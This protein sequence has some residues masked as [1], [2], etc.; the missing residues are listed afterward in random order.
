MHRVLE[1]IINLLAFLLTAGRPVTA[2][3]I[4]YQVA[5]YDQEGDDA[6]RR[7][8]ERDKDLIRR[9]GIPLTMHP[10]DQWEVEQGYV[11]VPDEY[12]LEDPGLTDDERSAL[13]AAAQIVRMGGTGTGAEAIFKLGGAPAQ[14]SNEPLAAD[15]G[16]DAGTLAVLFE[17]VTTRR[18]IRF[19]HRDSTRRLRPFGLVHRRGHWY[20]A[21]ED[22]ESGA[23]RSFRVDRLADVTAFGPENAFERPEGFR[24]SEAFASRPWE[25]GPDDIR[26]VVHFDA[27]VAW[28]ARRQLSEDSDSD[29]HS[30]GSLT[31]TIPVAHVDAFIGWLIGFEDQAEIVAPADLRRRF[32]AHVAGDS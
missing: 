31:A 11:V 16:A 20:V 28:W 26:A 25:A 7:T 15:L 14:A 32:V 24:A 5:G 17:S 18:T 30:D 9:L 3:E 1:R 4:R 13:W 12:G 8:F 21:G 22:A 2:E 10:T 19:S 23:Q 6:F 27:P 29:D